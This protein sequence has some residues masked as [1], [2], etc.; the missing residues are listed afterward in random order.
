[1]QSPIIRTVLSAFCLTIATQASIAEPR[2]TPTLLETMSL[3]LV[4]NYDLPIVAVMPTLVS[5]PAAEL[6]IRRYGPEANFPVGGVVALYDDAEGTIF[7]SEYWTGNTVGDLS[8]LVHELVH[9]MQ[10]AAG[11]RFACAG[12]REVLAYRAQDDWLGLFGSSLEDTFGI[13]PA[14]RLVA[15]TCTH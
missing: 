12:E 7:L 4:S 13:D 3:W 6:V 11:L 5:L 15:T 14:T 10:A 8:V 1:M 9:H 2:D